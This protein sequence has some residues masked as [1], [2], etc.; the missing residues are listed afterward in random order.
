MNVSVYSA[1]VLVTIVSDTHSTAAEKA[2][3][4][5]I[6]QWIWKKNYEVISSNFP[7]TEVLSLPWHQLAAVTWIWIINLF[8]H[9]QETSRYAQNRPICKLHCKAFFSWCWGFFSV[10][11]L[12]AVRLKDWC[13][14]YRSILNHGSLWTL[15][16]LW[17]I[18]RQTKHFCIKWQLIISFNTWT[19]PASGDN[20]HISLNIWNCVTNNTITVRHVELYCIRKSEKI[21]L[22]ISNR[23]CGRSL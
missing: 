4:R 1:N 22:A 7:A 3:R 17:G 16:N 10:L 12:V 19:Q 15:N 6:Q 2:C 21:M 23:K 18:Q 5:M 20:W 14:I 8:N 9:P 13:L 11:C